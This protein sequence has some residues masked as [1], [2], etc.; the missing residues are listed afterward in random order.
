ML[1]VRRKQ[2]R[3]ASDR[4]WERTS[5]S[6]VKRF[7]IPQISIYHFCNAISQRW[8]NNEGSL[9]APAWTMLQSVSNSNG[10]YNFH[11]LPV[12]PANKRMDKDIVANVVNVS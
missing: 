9:E 10:S 2:A 12:F 1:P 8:Y 3:L 6:S 5:A 11:P 4:T 7:V